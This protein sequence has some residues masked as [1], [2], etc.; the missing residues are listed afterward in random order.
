[1]RRLLSLTALAAIAA[2]LPAAAQTGDALIRQ[3]ASFTPVKNATFPAP[4]DQV[5]K[6]V[7]NIQAGAAKPTDVDPGYRSVASFI[8]QADDIGI[9]RKNL[10]LAMVI[11]GNSARTLLQNDA[12][13]T[14][15]GADNPNI[16]LLQALEAAGVQVIICGQSIP[17]RKLP[18]DKLLPFVK[19]SHSATFA[20][21]TL[22][23]Q[24]YYRFE[25]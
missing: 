16:A 6:A 1:M 9:P 13:K 8:V 23:S 2:A 21:V 19:V 11:H 10:Q 22:H 3:H 15:T 24:G 20:H 14:M 4:A 7:W 5:Y 25:N 17:N 12:Y 18:A